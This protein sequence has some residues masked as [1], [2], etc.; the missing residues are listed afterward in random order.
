MSFSIVVGLI[1]ALVFNGFFRMLL[2]VF[3]ADRWQS[4]VN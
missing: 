3:I 2:T 1:Q 4:L